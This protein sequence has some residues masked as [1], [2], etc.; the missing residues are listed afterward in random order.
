MTDQVYAPSLCEG[1]RHRGDWGVSVAYR[2]AYRCVQLG[3]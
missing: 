3:G 2:C 1:E